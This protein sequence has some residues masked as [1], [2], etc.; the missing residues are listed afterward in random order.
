MEFCK[1][2]VQYRARDE[3]LEKEKETTHILVEGIAGTIEAEDQG[4]RSARSIRVRFPLTRML[5][6]RGTS[7]ARVHF[8]IE[9][10][11]SGGDR[12]W[13]E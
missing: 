7:E 10:V 4:P 1:R 12:G 3:G 2:G 11:S 8:W 13:T 5:I 9:G 6:R